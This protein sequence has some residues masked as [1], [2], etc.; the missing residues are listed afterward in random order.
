LSCM[1]NANGCVLL[2]CQVKKFPPLQFP[3]PLSRKHVSSSCQWNGRHWIGLVSYCLSVQWVCAGVAR[4]G[5]GRRVTECIVQQRH[6]Q[7]Q[8]WVGTLVD[9]RQQQW[10][11]SGGGVRAK[12]FVV[13]S[14]RH[15][16][17]SWLHSDTQRTDNGQSVCLNHN[18]QIKMKKTLKT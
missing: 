15:R 8:C 7:R 18:V 17:C 12:I 1:C 4:C 6:E 3:P 5:G 2:I 16:H 13:Q 14:T 11:E 10:H 9:R